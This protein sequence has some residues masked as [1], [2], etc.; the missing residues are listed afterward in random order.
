M[1]V[2]P[3]VPLAQPLHVRCNQAAQRPQPR[4]H[5]FYT[6]D[7]LIFLSFVM[8]ASAS[9]PQP[10][11]FCIATSRPL[12]R[13]LRDSAKLQPV[14][15]HQP[16]ATR[17]ST[18]A[19]CTL[20]LTARVHPRRREI[21]ACDACRRGS[22]PARAPQALNSP[23]GHA[24]H[25]QFLCPFTT[26]APPQAR[27][28]AISSHSPPALSRVDCGFVRDG[29]MAPMTPRKLVPPATAHSNPAFLFL[30][31]ELMHAPR[32]D[33]SLRPACSIAQA[34]C[35]PPSAARHGIVTF[36]NARP[37]LVLLL[38]RSCC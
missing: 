8:F 4:R 28:R 6:S 7:V 37:C 15:P 26:T 16:E 25:V 23:T 33:P 19:R 31:P 34:P 12:C 9:V 35:P 27:H 30:V 29:A 13:H 32:A 14:V 38:E 2:E 20:H 21:D 1:C 18:K 24:A 10:A 3:E 5:T 17:K 22:L 36:A 11:C